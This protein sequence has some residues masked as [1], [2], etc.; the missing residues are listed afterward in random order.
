MNINKEG[1]NYCFSDLTDIP[2][3]RDYV[4]N[5][6][7]F[8]EV[9]TFT[10]FKHFADP[11]KIAIDIGAWIGFTPIWLCNNFKHVMCIEADNKSIISL[12]NNQFYI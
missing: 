10:V 12:E 1:V 5:H 7:S 3:I 9:D 6:F 11:S 8:W 4:I 2:N